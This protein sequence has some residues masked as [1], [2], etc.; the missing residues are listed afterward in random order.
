MLEPKQ[1]S[2]D[3]PKSTNSHLSSCIC[4]SLPGKAPKSNFKNLQVKIIQT[5]KCE[6]FSHVF[7]SLP[8]S[9]QCDFFY[10]FIL[11][12]KMP[13]GWWWLWMCAAAVTLRCTR[14]PGLMTAQPLQTFQW[15]LFPWE[16]PA[17]Q[18]SLWSNPP[19]YLRKDKFSLPLS[20]AVSS[21]SSSL[22]QLQQSIVVLPS[23]QTGRWSFLCNDTK[24]HARFPLPATGKEN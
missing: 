21:S 11:R 5:K 10:S 9:Q 15:L 4:F 19:L 13:S 20:L 22:S 8:R 17:E 23:R 24:S 18:W 7:S 3:S 16:A 6:G 14:S 12:S 2:S 1:L